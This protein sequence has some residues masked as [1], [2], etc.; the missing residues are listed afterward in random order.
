MVDIDE[1]WVPELAPDVDPT[2][3]DRQPTPEEFFVLS[4]IDGTSTVEAIC[5]TSGL[6]RQKT[7]D[8]IAQLYR[9]GLINLPQAPD[10]SSPS[11]SEKSTDAGDDNADK[12]SL[13][14]RLRQRFPIPFRDFEFDEELLAQS[15]ELEDPFKKEVLFVHGQLDTVNHYE[16]LG[17]SDDAKRRALRSAYFK[18]SKRYH[19]DRFYKKILGDYQAKI[20]RIF[21]RVTKAYQTLSNRNK[22]KKYDATLARGRE[23]HATPVAASTPAGHRSEPREDLGQNRKRDMAYKVLVQR[24]DKALARGA[25][26][27][28]I[29]EFQKA[30][31]LQRDE[32]LALRI[33]Q[34]LLEQPDH[35]EDAIA[36][37][38]AA[39]KI[40]PESPAAL[41][42]IGD[43]YARRQQSDDALTHYRQAQA[44]A[45]DDDALQA[46]IARHSD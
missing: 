33:A 39:Q 46:R 22:R 44:L 42:L 43:I 12:P 27:A 21:Q 14:D 19:P 26:G 29:K 17:V 3:L 40:N 5:K 20:E 25:V 9:Y 28:A 18:L 36:F 37:A 30:L 41:T 45:P 34:A 32:E 10:T 6:G 15:V 11:T 16:L 23:D 24:G 7:A 35:L 31:S 2:S 38:R 1:N 8:S 4:R 13:A